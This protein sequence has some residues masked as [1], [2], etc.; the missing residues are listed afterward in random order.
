MHGRKRKSAMFFLLLTLITFSAPNFNG[1]MNFTLS[2]SPDSEP[3]SSLG[4]KVLWEKTCG[5]TGDDRAFY[6]ITVADGFVVVGSSTSFKQ[7]KTVAWVL[8]LNQDGNELWNRTYFEE[9]GCEFRSVLG[10]DNGFLLVGNVFLS[11]GDIDGYVVRVDSEGKTVWNSTLGGENV[12]RLFSALETQDGFVLAGLTYSFGDN[13]QVW[14]VKT[15]VNGNV[16]WSKTY[17]GVMED[18]GRAVA[19]S[20]DNYY[21]VAGYTNSMGNGDYDFLLLKI[22]A[23]GS[24]SWNKTYGGIQSE[25]AYAI[26]ETVDG[27]VAVGDTRS[28]GEGDSDAWITKV[29]LN[30]NLVW[31]ETAGGEVFDTATCVTTSNYEGYLVGGF[32]FSFGSGERD[33]WLFKVN[34]QGSV[35]WSCTVGRSAFEEAYEVLETGESEFVMAGW[36]NSIGQGRY[37]FY[38][39]EISAENSSDGLSAYQFITSASVLIAIALIVLIV[40]FLLIRHHVNQKISRQNA[41]ATWKP[42]V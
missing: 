30:G 6:A 16:A 12:D 15:D 28:K 34:D 26:A 11:S 18:A 3:V 23:S 17:G 32:T 9:D 1:A 19:L 5:G 10:L 13:S 29:D 27:C 25:K 37:D 38:V 41:N 39:T 7:Y 8:K 24:L 31:D 35:Q 2:A 22:D 33:F 40:L 14:V 42:D 4:A 36:T 20:E 21:V